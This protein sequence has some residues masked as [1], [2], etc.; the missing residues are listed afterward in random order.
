MHHLG[1]TC[2]ILCASPDYIRARGAPQRP[3][4]LVD[5]ECLILRTPAFPANLWLL[6]GPDGSEP[7]EVSGAVEVNIAE[8]LAVAIRAGMGIGVL[9]V[10][11]AIAGLRNGTL[12]RVLPA[13]TLQNM[14]VYALYPS[15]RFLDAK[16]RTWVEFLRL[17]LPQVIER[18]QAL[19]EKLTG[20]RS[21]AVSPAPAASATATSRASDIPS[22]ALPDKPN[23][24]V[25]T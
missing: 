2:S 23:I 9:P 24:T 12:V 22:R 13:H 5:H 21:K 11:A 8:S 25:E 18:D 1:S 6:D 4:D 7:M 16:T 3:S 17:H 20:D 15:R 19:L 10:Y 14:N